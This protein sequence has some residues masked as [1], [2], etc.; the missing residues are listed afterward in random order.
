MGQPGRAIALPGVG[1]QGRLDQLQVAP[2]DAVLVEA[3]DLVEL[4]GDARLDPVLQLVAAAAVRRVEAGV[5]QAGEIAGEARVGGQRLL[6]VGLAER[7]ADLQDVVAVGAQGHDLAR[8]Q[9]G[10]EH[11][12]VEAV[13]LQPA[14]P[15]A[16]EQVLEVLADRIDVD[17]VA[18]HRAAARSRAAE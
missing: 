3:R 2:Q 12:A 13:V 17:R 14:G 4:L 5:E 7:R 10:G 8:A 1:A 11:Q 16:G 15:D 9:P 18:D 6:D